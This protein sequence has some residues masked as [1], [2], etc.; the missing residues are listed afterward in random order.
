MKKTEIMV[1]LMIIMLVSLIIGIKRVEYEGMV[2]SIPQEDID[3][4]TI[5]EAKQQANKSIKE[6]E[7]HIKKI[8]KP[9][10]EILKKNPKLKG[11]LRRILNTIL[12]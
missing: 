2:P 12:E 8:E 11:F 6:F 9:I 10:K 7:T 5:N 3:A 1:G 4:N